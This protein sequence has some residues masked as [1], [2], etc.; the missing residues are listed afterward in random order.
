VMRFFTASAIASDSARVST[1]G[2]RVAESPMGAFT[3]PPA[4]AAT[5]PEVPGAGA[6]AGALFAVTAGTP[7]SLPRRLHDV[8]ATA[9]PARITRSAP[10]NSARRCRPSDVDAIPGLIVGV[11][12]G[13]IPLAGAGCAC[14]L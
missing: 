2:S 12:Q 1:I 5:A 6:E 14:P 8:I 4:I 11:L 9:T 7:P 3:A 13:P 10:A